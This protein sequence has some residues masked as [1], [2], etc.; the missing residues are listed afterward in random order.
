MKGCWPIRAMCRVLDVSESGYYSWQAAGG[1]PR[2]RR[3]PD[4]PLLVHIRAIHREEKGE[5]GWPRIHQELQR[6]GL[7]VGKE[8]VRRL[9]KTHGSHAR[10]KRKCVYTTDSG[11]AVL[12]AAGPVQR[13]C[14]PPAPDQ[15]WC[16]DITYLPR[17]QGWLYLAAVIDLF[18]RKIVGWSLK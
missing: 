13:Q 8:R 18:S 7:R 10:S 5:Y 14:K 15:I 1:V 3:L 16:G 4:E 6:R 12:L 2:G 11:Q 17:E 9:M